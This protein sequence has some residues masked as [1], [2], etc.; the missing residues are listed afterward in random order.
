MVSDIFDHDET[1]DDD[2]H[3]VVWGRIDRKYDSEGGVFQGDGAFSLSLD[4]STGFLNGT[5]EAQL[6]TWSQAESLHEGFAT[7]PA[8]SF[9]MG[10]AFGEGWSGETDGDG[11]TVSVYVSEFAM[12]TTEVT[13]AQMAE[14]MNWA[15]GQGLITASAVTISNTEGSYVK[16][17]LHINSSSTQLSWTGSTLVVDVGKENY[18]V[19]NVTWYGAVAYA[20][21]KSRM[22]GYSGSYDIGET[23]SCDFSKAGYRLPTEAEWEKAARGGLSG[24][25]YPWGDLISHEQANYY[26]SPGSYPGLEDGDTSGY[27]EDWGDDTSPVASFAPNGYGLYDM[28]GN[29]WEWCN[30]W[31]DSD[32]YGADTSDPQGAFTGSLRVFRGGGW[33]NYANNARV[34]D[35]DRY[36]PTFSYYDLG[37]RLALVQ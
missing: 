16:E 1:V 29:L 33:D 12:Q 13:N 19:Q 3:S 31:Y 23:W 4:D 10:D 11:N 9:Q 5:F 28:A 18:P 34:A 7:I 22:D 2:N 20:S 14:V 8:G 25:R 6:G 32:Y 35:R 21:Y 26:A 24:K 30:D 27:H 17:L 15:Y 36:Y 37:F